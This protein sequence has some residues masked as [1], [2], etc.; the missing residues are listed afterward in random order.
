VSATD[1]ESKMKFYFSLMDK[2]LNHFAGP[3]FQEEVRLA[4]SDFFDNAGI[5]DERSEQFELRM[6]Q[7]FD[8]YF[9]TRELRGFSQTPLE[10]VHMARPLRFTDE[11]QQAIDAMKNHRH[12]LFE[13]QKIKGNDIY[14]K[15]LLRGDK[16]V[17]KECPWTFGFDSDELFEARLVPQRDN[18]YF[19]KGF[20]FHP[21]E[22]KKFILSE[23][24]SHKKDPDLN[25]EDMMLRLIKMRYKFERYRHVK[26][27]LI[28]S[29]ESKVGI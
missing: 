19:M 26:I 2:I 21:R 22:A 23:V 15:D 6:S 13:F 24:K 11:E 10:S 29:S 25:P 27:D 3:D 5:L 8:W 18:W 12:S 9:F 28:Y 16:I 4:K 14:L 20:C 7:F 17:V 1:S